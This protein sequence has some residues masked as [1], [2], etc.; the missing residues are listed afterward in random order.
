MKE[1]KTL[2][3]IHPSWVTQSGFNAKVNTNIW[4]ITRQ[5]FLFCF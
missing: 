4:K 3:H 2:S 1:A 5:V